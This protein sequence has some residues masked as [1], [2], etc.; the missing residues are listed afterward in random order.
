[1]HQNALQIAVIG[2]GHGGKSM[3]ADLA[4]KGFSVRLYNRTAAHIEAIKLRGGIQLLSEDGRERFGPLARVTAN[5]A[6]AIEDA[7]LIM[8]VIPACGHRDIA[9][10]AAAHLKDEQVL[11]LNPGRTGGALEFTAGLREMNCTQH[12]II[13]EAE[14]FIFAARSMGPAEARIFR[15]K[16]S[17]PVSAMPAKRTAE[18][19][20]I[21]QK[22]YPQFIFRYG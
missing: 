5:M 15:T 14:T 8:V 17:I 9:L 7:H 20:E 12:P 6:E 18:A 13:C 16:F 22:V 3:A 19:I 2:A 10:Q 11:V 21:I 4:I 1:M